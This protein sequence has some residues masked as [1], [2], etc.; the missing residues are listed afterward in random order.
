MK[1][2][3]YHDHFVYAKN[4]GHVD[5]QVINQ[6]LPEALEFLGRVTPFRSRCL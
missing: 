4:A 1:T 5:A 6:T 2:K 3:G